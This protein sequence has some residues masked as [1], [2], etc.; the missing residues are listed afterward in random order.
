MADIRRLLRIMWNA[1]VRVT[2]LR[3]CKHCGYGFY[4]TDACPHCE[5]LR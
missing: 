5:I 4:R 3:V 1:Y 2:G